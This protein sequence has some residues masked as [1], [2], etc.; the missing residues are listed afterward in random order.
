MPANMQ[1]TRRPVR[2]TSDAA[3]RHATPATGTP[4]SE[5]VVPGEQTGASADAPAVFDSTDV[6]LPNLFD[7]NNALVAPD[8]E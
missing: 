2:P 7:R 6:I 3:D 8:G 4:D 5:S 1:T